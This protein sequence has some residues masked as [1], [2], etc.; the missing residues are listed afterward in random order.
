[1]LQ[2]YESTFDQLGKE[3]REPNSPGIKKLSP[4]DSSDFKSPMQAKSRMRRG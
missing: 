2:K 1:M 4:L 3:A